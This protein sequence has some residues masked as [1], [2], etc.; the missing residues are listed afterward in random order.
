MPPVPTGIAAYS[1][2]IVERLKPHHLIEVYPEH[3]AHDFIWTHQQRPFDLVVFQ[4]G[5]SSHHDYVWPYLFRYPGLVVLHDAHL[6][7]ARAAALLRTGRGGDYRVE[8][9][10]NHP[11]ASADAAELAIAGFDNYLYYSW[12]FVRLIVNRSRTTVVHNTRMAEQLRSW[13]PDVEIATVRMSHGE[14]LDSTRRRNSRASVRQQYGIPPDDI[15]FGVMGGLTPDKRVPQILSAFQATLAHVPDARL[16]LAGAP[17]EH[18]D[19]AADVGARNLNNRVT[20]TGYLERDSDFTDHLAACDVSI[21]LRWPTAREVSGPWLRALAVECPTITMDLAHMA[22]VPALDPRTWTIPLSSGR[23]ATQPVTVAVDVLDE[24]HSLR[25]TMR[26]L[27]ADGNLREQ[28]AV[29]GLDYWLREHSPEGMVA[30]YESVIDATIRK[31][32]R[33][34]DDQRSRCPDH[35]VDS[36]DRKLRRLVERFDVGEK[37]WSRL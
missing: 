1:A 5:N 29:A 35:L 24:D 10:A 34:S 11:E 36:A 31:T 28:L 12:P 32:P 20:L 23:P 14:Q 6:H 19:V 30:D 37:L 17:P 9:A 2:E 13:Y 22:D 4:L 7:H 16:L 3:S 15:L 25:L 18:Y 33:W 26:R 21:N 27:A 8:F